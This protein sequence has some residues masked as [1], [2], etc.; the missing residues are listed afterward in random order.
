M[1]FT[2]NGDLARNQIELCRQIGIIQ[3]NQRIIKQRID[4]LDS[5]QQELN[6]KLDTILQILTSKENDK[7]EE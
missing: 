7:G 6:E 1:C 3:Q 2:T 4:K 5:N